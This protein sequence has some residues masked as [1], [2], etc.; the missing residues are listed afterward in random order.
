MTLPGRGT[1]AA[2]AHLPL[3]ALL[4][5][6][7]RALL[8]ALLLLALLLLAL[9]LQLHAASC[10]LRCLLAM[11]PPWWLLRGGRGASLLVLVLDTWGGTPAAARGHSTGR[12]YASDPDFGG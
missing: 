6:L 4:F 8:T 5:V 9:L 3:L 12:G 1:A 10:W 2:Q 11:P 7:K